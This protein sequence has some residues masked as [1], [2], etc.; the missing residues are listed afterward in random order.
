MAKT[1]VQDRML[2][3][4]VLD[5]IKKIEHVKINSHFY[6]RDDMG[7][8]I[9]HKC[10][11]CETPIQDWI[12]TVDGREAFLPLGNYRMATFNLDDGSKYTTNGCADCLDKLDKNDSDLLEALYLSDVVGLARVDELIGVGK[13]EHSKR[14]QH[15]HERKVL[16]GKK[17]IFNPGMNSSR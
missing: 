3:K 16:I 17:H 2:P 6:V 13:V 14:M 1:D 7:N 11:F 10:R 12:K 4:K 15:M 5:R 8:P 9:V